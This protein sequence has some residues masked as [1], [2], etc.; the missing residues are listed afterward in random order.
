MNSDERAE[1]LL[2]QL[3]Q[4]AMEAVERPRREREE[5]V[6]EVG[7]RYYEDAVKN[8]LSASQAEAWRES[9]SEWLRDLIHVIETSGG[10]GGGQG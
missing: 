3:Q 5:F 10:A 4:W 6:Q 9:V 2:A 1:R 8:G 7:R